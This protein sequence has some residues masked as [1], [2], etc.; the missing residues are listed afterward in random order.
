MVEL[1]DFVPVLIAGLPTLRLLLEDESE[2]A[3][4]EQLAIRAGNSKAA[5]Q[6]I[7]YPIVLE[8][9]AYGRLLALLD[10]V[11]GEVQQF[12]SDL[13]GFCDD[14]FDHSIE[15]AV[16]AQ[17]FGGPLRRV[18]RNVGQSPARHRPGILPFVGEA[19]VQRLQDPLILEQPLNVLL[20]VAAEQPGDNLQTGQGYFGVGVPGPVDDALQQGLVVGELL[21]DDIVIGGF[22]EQS[23]D[24]LEASGIVLQQPR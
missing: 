19:I 15:Q 13:I 9:G 6:H 14:H 17:H 2:A 18:H 5:A 3:H 16:V 21:Q 11:D 24:A 10:G 8:E 23:S 1:S 4:G 22:L 20:I 7:N 12:F